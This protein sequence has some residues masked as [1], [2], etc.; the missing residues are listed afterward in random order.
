[1]DLI[2]SISLD[3]RVAGAIKSF[4]ANVD[5]IVDLTVAIQQIPSPTFEE[6]ERAA[7]VESLY[8]AAGLDNVHMDDIHNVFGRHPGSNSQKPVVISA[9]LDTVFPAGTD[10]AV[11]YD[12]HKREASRIYG[13]GLADNSLGVAG[14]II[15]A[16]TLQN[17]GIQTESDVWLVANVAEEGLGN[18]KGMRAVV[19]KFG[20]DATYLVLEGGSFGL[21]FHEAI[22]VNRFLIDARTPGGH[23]WGDFG[24][25]NA[26]HILSSL[27]S[28]ISNLDV[29]AEPKTTFNVGVIEGGTTVN[30]IASSAQCQLDLRSADNDLLAR[31]TE[32]IG[33]LVGKANGQPAVQVEMTQIGQRP[34]G[35]ISRESTIVELA[36]AALE[37][38]GCS[39]VKYMA[40]STDASIPISRGIPSVCIGLAKSGNTHRLDEFVDITHLS[41]GLSQLLLLALA[42]AGIEG[43]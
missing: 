37:Q 25:P 2:N 13:P 21:V 41:Q 7:Y 10:L 31:L 30:A 17:G 28:E 22:G 24:K 43:E 15:L 27:I 35:S 12:G 3:I 4:D 16:Q 5:S 14:L 42:T 20:T 29:P 34:S 39:P 1:M 9:H 6:A 38:V 32:Q 18:L 36:A 33:E 26:I 11:R 23:S 40:G 8:A 19:D